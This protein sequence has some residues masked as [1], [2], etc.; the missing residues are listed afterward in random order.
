MTISRL[1]RLQLRIMLVLW[2]KGRATA[3]EITET[4]NQDDRIAHS[5]VQT[6]LRGLERKGAVT[7]DVRGRTFIYLP[8]KNQEKARG[9][10]AHEVIDRLLPSVHSPEIGF[11]PLGHMFDAP[12]PGFVGFLCFRLFVDIPNRRLDVGP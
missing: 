12:E 10:A 9:N 8:L 11:G 5:T 2:K 1:G 4:L 6:L 3:R 7:H